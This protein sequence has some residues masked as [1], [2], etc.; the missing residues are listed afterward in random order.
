MSKNR[1]KLLSAVHLLLVRN[2]EVLLL[3]RYNTGYEDGNYSVPAGHLDGNEP[4]STAMARE[5]REEVGLIID[6]AALE[7]VHV[8]HRQA[9]NAADPTNERVD[10]Y[11]TVRNWTGEPRIME[12]DKCDE[13]S[14]HPL[15]RL[16]LNTIPYIRAA[17]D[18]FLSGEYYSEYGWAPSERYELALSHD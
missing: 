13:L 8:M 2:G 17:F 15:E 9:S 11:L 5:A 6:P 16:P 12:P 14:W 18:S 10:F 4:V 7:V 1:F 3:R